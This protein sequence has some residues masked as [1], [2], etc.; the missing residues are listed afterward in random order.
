MGMSLLRA[1]WPTLFHLAWPASLTGLMRI[2]MRTIDLVVVGAVVGAS[3]VAAVGIADAAA[4]LVLLV[5]LGLAAGTAATVSQRHGAGDVAGT[6]AAATQTALIAMGLGTVATVA[7]L[8][9]SA[10]FFD[11]LG[12]DGAVAEDGTTYLT[13]VLAT[14]VPRLMTTMLDRVY[15][16]VGDTRTPMLVR[17]TAT[18]VNI[19]L[20]VLL[21]GG[22]AGLPALGVTGAAVGTAVGD[23]LAGVAMTSILASRRYRTV[24]FSRAGLADVATGR[25]ILAIGAPQAFERSLYAMA[26]IP[27]NG[28]VL[29]FGAE[30][31]AGYNVG[32][33]ILLLGVIPNRGVAIAASTLVGNNVGARD[34]DAGGRYG[35]GALA[36]SVATGIVAS[37]L[38]L[39]FARP[40]ASLF[41]AAEPTATAAIVPWVRAFALALPFRGL[42]AVMRGAMQGSGET[43][44]PLYASA[45][46]VLG[47]LL[48][49]SWLF[50]HLAGLGLV[51]I[52]TAIVADPIT[53]VAMLGRWWQN[54]A[55]RRATADPEV[56]TGPSVREPSP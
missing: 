4:R 33:R 38:L 34:V 19:G 5:A 7:G 39:V 35:Q 6:H 12:A 27:L 20:T 29:T 37:V 22:L 23:V 14:S 17:M 2:A 49:G 21:V 11:L 13:I 46:G 40:V 41:A 16:S 56:A 45:V 54:G 18:S 31:N 47:V 51:A 32:R 26:S 53:R 15:Q 24:G 44:Y 36:M 3:G 43:R 25:R 1:T 10:A 28:L 42:F 8:L 52:H 30:A 55:W 50:G 9:G 48:G